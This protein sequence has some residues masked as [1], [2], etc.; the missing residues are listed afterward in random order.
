MGRINTLT[1]KPE[2]TDGDI[3]P[4]WDS[5]AGRTRSILA[6]SL[7]EYIQ[8][9]AGENT[10]VKSGTLEND[11]LTLTLTDGSTVNVPMPFSDITAET[12]KLADDIKKTNDD[13]ANLK[14]DKADNLILK[15]TPSAKTVE[16]ELKSG[17]KTLVDSTLDLSD[18]F[19]ENP[20]VGIH[21]VGIYETLGALDTAYTN[22]KDSL[23]AI[24]LGPTEK[25]YYSN[26]GA[27]L[28]LG[29]VS[30]FHNGYLGVYDTLTA[31]QTA[32]PGANTNDMAIVGTTT[33]RFY[34]FN[35]SAWEPVTT[36]DLS[37]LS[38]RMSTAE[39]DITALQGETTDNAK[40]IA[41]LQ[42]SASDLTTKTNA[43]D[44]RATILETWRTEATPKI[45]SLETVT[46]SN[47]QR[48]D[49]LEKT[50]PDASGLTTKVNKNAQD[51]G[52]L[53]TKLGGVDTDIRQ[54]QS[55]VYTGNTVVGDN[56][57]SLSDITG[58]EFVGADVSD[59]DL[60]GVATVRVSPKFTV[61][62]G[63]LAGSKTLTGNALI[64]P[65]STLVADPNDPNVIIVDLPDEFKGNVISDDK[66]HE[67]QHITNLE[68]KNCNITGATEEKV[69]IEVDP[70]GHFTGSIVEDKVGASLSDVVTFEFDGATVSSQTAGKARIT[71]PP[72]NGAS[73]LDSR[74]FSYQNIESFNFATATVDKTGDG[75]VT[76]RTVSN[77]ARI[78]ISDGSNPRV[79]GTDLVFPNA[80]IK[81]D[82]INP[83]TVT[84]DMPAVFGGSDVSGTISGNF[85]GIT[86]F[87]FTNATVTTTDANKTAVVTINTASTQIDVSNGV[88]AALQG[89][90]LIFPNSRVTADTVNPQT[91]TVEMIDTFL[92]L[93][94]KGSLSGSFGQIENLTFNGA[95]VTTTDGGKTA[96]ISIDVGE[97]EITVT[98]G[99]DTPLKGTTL[100]FPDAILTQESATEISVGIKDT[101]T[102][103]MSMYSSA[104]DNGMA[105]KSQSILADSTKNGWWI[106]P[107]AT[108]TR[109]RPPGSV[110]DLIVF[111][112]VIDTPAKK[113]H[114]IAI[115]FGKNTNNADS[116]WVSYRPEARAWLPWFSI[117]KDDTAAL[118]ELNGNIDKLKAQDADLHTK[119]AALQ[120]EIGNVYAPTKTVFDNH[121]ND[122]IQAAIKN[123][124]PHVFENYPT[125]YA[126]GAISEPVSLQGTEI[127][128][129]G[130]VTLTPT[131]LSYKIFIF[132]ENENNQAEKVRGWRISGGPLTVLPSKDVT[133]DSKSYK[134]FESLGVFADRVVYIDMVI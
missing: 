19:V 72:R 18:W 53:N 111:K 119:L 79:E 122:L 2:L 128:T 42:T 46:T 57:Q 112:N 25:Y 85:T 38:T 129:S 8:V 113:P 65:D 63:Q 54:L 62:D 92:G 89:N 74:G 107:D 105:Q 98:N 108:Q 134:I 55:E 117:G 97:S 13:L 51:I 1:V 28:V 124:N 123:A 115:A 68:F 86:A 41:S 30:K 109:T 73:I 59:D 83:S 31:L 23:Q 21:F 133:I 78:G 15:S 126:I 35:G 26:G 71:I 37:S 5:K 103:D 127:S 60:D 95:N 93:V 96:V 50:H 84:I 3:I 100:L 29:E 47:E 9:K 94:V 56:K 104:L 87:S 33:K 40:D 70:L 49:A 90:A 27:W 110:G 58:F 125:L 52:T 88:D 24:V 6:D 99:K 12:T 116:I 75:Q 66:G 64:F 120:S 132:V 36:V 80:L 77:D 39:S 114:G 17:D 10:H 20:V 48:I 69:I 44:N 82:P 106:F 61:G 102:F 118:T 4:I 16:Y 91:L 76:I 81:T 7:K 130:R 43:L 11:L 32:H 34:T 67:F 45:G 101:P 14:T 22:P 121:V 131:L